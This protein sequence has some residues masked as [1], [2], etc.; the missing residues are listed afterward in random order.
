[1]YLFLF[2]N[3]RY[4]RQ[5]CKAL[6]QIRIRGNIVFHCSVHI[7]LIR[8]HIKI[9]GS[10][11]AEENRFGF[12]GFFA[13]ESLLYGTVDGMCGLRC[14]QEAGSTSYGANPGDEVWGTAAIKKAPVSAISAGTEACYTVFCGTTRLDELILRSVH[15][16]SYTVP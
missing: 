6:F 7:G 2:L 16:L 15:V 1:M 11:Q 8:I 13:F 14:R 3:P 10:G 5:S 12:P 9:S 4:L